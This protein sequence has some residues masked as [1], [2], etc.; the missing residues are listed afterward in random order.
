MHNIIGSITSNTL[1]ISSEVGAAI[2]TPRHLLLN[3]PIIFEVELAQRISRHVAIYFSMVLL[4]ACWA[5][6][7]SLSTSVSTTTVKKYV[8][9]FKM[10]CKQ[11]K[12][13]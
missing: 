5:S 3:G 7:V 12:Y 6:F 11:L 4:K 13:L 9:K 10:C 8:S 2:L 1:I